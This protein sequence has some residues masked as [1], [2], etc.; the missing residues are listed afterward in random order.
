MSRRIYVFAAL[1]LAIGILVP[2]AGLLFWPQETT[3]LTITTPTPIQP[4]PTNNPVQPSIIPQPVTAA[5]LVKFS[6]Y[7]ELITY[8]ESVLKTEETAGAG[9]TRE[10][11]VNQPYPLLVTA[12]S[13]L[14]GG[15]SSVAGSIVKMGS[16]QYSGTNVQ[17]AGIDEPDIVKTNGKIIAVASGNKIYLVDPIHKKVVSILEMNHTITGLLLENNTLAVIMSNKTSVNIIILGEPIEKPLGNTELTIISLINITDPEK[18]VLVKTFTVSG[19]LISARLYRGVLYVVTAQHIGEEN[20]LPIVNNKPVPIRNI[21]LASTPPSTYTNIIAINTETL[22]YNV[23]SLIMSSAS[24]IYM[25]YHHLIVVSPAENMYMLA[26][27]TILHI[28]IKLLPKN[29]ASNITG[30]LENNTYQSIMEAYRIF[31]DYVSSLPV[32]EAEKLAATINEL[33]NYREIAPATKFYV[34]NID[35]VKIAYKGKFSINGTLYNQF[36]MDEYMNKFFV[37]ATNYIKIIPS[38][39]VYSYK[40]VQPSGTGNINIIITG[41]NGERKVIT[42]TVNVYTSSN[43]RLIVIIDYRRVYRANQLAIVDLD[44]LKKVSLISNIAPGEDIKTARMIGDLFIL[45]TYRNIDPLFAINIRDPYH[46]KVIGYLKIPGYNVYLHP[47]KDGLLLGI[48]VDRG[49]LTVSLY[50]ISDPAHVAEISRAN[51]GRYITSPVL[52]D[53]HAFTII[54]DKDVFI[55][56]LSR[57]WAWASGATTNT[58]VWCRWCFGF[59]IMRYSDNGLELIKI[60]E[61]PGGS[62]SLYIDNDLYLVSQNKILVLDMENYGIVGEIKL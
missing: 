22:Q 15:I 3:P 4:F 38:I 56:P 49:N 31:Y 54:P 9:Y 58:G 6:S 21:I 53:Y 33:I 29:I 11:T 57:G 40:P 55:I 60:V 41:P 45:V 37:V 35:G 51:I 48:G 43:N 27:K 44:T 23:L 28:S 34:F 12:V 18:P 2:I 25:S 62:R 47:L 13:T 5:N 42:T 17:V 52:Y 10:G 46:P 24:K 19:H 32:D 39:D 61:L 30:L 16:V 8:L 1:A 20:L 14:S 36:C 26:V 59:L 7:K 50:N